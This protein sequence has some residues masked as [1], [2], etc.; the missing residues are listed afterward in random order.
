MGEKVPVRTEK[1]PVRTEK[2]RDALVK[3]LLEICDT[4]SF[5]II[6]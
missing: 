4:L 2:V 1:V 3:G 5:G 6:P